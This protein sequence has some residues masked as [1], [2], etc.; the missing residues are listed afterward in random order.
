VTL[1]FIDPNAYPPSTPHPAFVNELVFNLGALPS[2]LGDYAIDYPSGTVYVFGQDLTNSGTG[3]E[4]PLATYNY[5]YT[6]VSEMDYVYDTTDNNLV[7]LP[8]GSLLNNAGNIGFNYEQVLIPGID[9]M[10]NLHVENLSEN[11]ENR[12]LGF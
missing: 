10:A 11:V 9:Y 6:Y 8:N 3:P 12:L 4:P 5:L 7:A 1:Y 2:T